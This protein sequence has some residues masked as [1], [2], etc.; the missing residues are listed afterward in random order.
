MSYQKPRTQHDYRDLVWSLIPLVLICVVFA[1][2]ASQCSFSAHGPTRGNIPSFDLDAALQ[3]DAHTLS[4]P[5]R[6]PDLPGWTPNSGSRDTVTGTGGGDVST[7]G[8]ITPQ[9]TY[10]QLTQSNATPDALAGH[11]E[12]ARHAGGTQQLGD[13]TWSVY[14]QPGSEPAWVTDFGT[15]RVLIKGAGDSA[16]FDAMAN[17]VD[18]AQPLV[19][20]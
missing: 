8:F 3:A 11:I 6:K 2:V 17:A 14:H 16:A 12:G 18:A 13:R 1:A 7:V 4:F 19:A 15:V 20:K 10:M 9:G 5:V